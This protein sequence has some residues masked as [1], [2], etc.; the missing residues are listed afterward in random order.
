ML[1]CNTFHKIAF[2]HHLFSR[3]KNRILSIVI[4]IQKKEVNIN[5]IIVLIIYCKLPKF[6]KFRIVAVLVILEYQGSTA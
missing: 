5:K 6:L 3:Y 4:L 1:R 2:A